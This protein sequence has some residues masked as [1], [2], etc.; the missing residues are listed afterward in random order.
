[1]EYVDAVWGMAERC[2]EMVVRGYGGVANGGVECDGAGV[3][4]CAVYW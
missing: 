4:W 2:G 3:W 1:M